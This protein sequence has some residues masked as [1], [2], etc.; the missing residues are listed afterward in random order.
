MG[1]EKAE[2]KEAEVVAELRWRL[3]LSKERNYVSNKRRTRDGRGS[4]LRAEH[5]WV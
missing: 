1:L 4:D 2:Q 5:L 3:G